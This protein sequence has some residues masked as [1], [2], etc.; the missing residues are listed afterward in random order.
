MDK[1]LQNLSN[2]YAEYKQNNE[3]YLQT[4]KEMAAERKAE[5]AAL[6]EK[7]KAEEAALKERRRTYSEWL[8]NNFNIVRTINDKDQSIYKS[9]S[10]TRDPYCLV[11]FEKTIPLNDII[12]FE[13]EKEFECNTVS[14]TTQPGSIGNALVGGLI[15][16][17][18]G[19]VVGASTTDNISK[20]TTTIKQ[21]VT[22]LTLYLSNYQEPLYTITGDESFIKQIYATLIAM[23]N[24]EYCI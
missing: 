3:K 11:L 23:K 10:F 12:K 5:E 1:N 19:A 7:R 20:S 15:A 8:K 16:G 4:Q 6:E 14:T 18:A 24:S 2:A 13:C 17:G 21:K 22:A 9:V